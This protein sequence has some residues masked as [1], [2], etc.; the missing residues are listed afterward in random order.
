MK[1]EETMAKMT[2]NQYDLEKILHEMVELKTLMKTLEEDYEQVSS[3]AWDLMK[4]KKQ[5]I[6][7]GTFTK[8]SREYWE[9]KDKCALVKEMTFKVYKEN[10]T[11]SKSGIVKGIGEKGF[12]KMKDA[13]VVGVKSVANFFIFKPTK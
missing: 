11:I 7:A 2:K 6:D 9:V 12:E 1:K 10:S 8:S 5:T 13:D 4:T 3:K